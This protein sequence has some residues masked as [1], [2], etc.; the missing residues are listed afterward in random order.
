MTMTSAVSKHGP[1]ALPESVPPGL[2]GVPPPPC[3]GDHDHLRG[4][5]ALGQQHL[6]LVLPL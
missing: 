2:P 4:I 1:A 5:Q 6:T 3:V